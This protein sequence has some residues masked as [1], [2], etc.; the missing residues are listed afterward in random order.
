MHALVFNYISV[1]LRVAG[2][3]FY[4]WNAVEVIKFVQQESLPFFSIVFLYLFFYHISFSMCFVSSATVVPSFNNFSFIGVHYFWLI[5]FSKL[6]TQLL[7][8][9]SG[10]ESI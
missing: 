5:L 4:K 7:S 6:V 1:Y 8:L 9:V 10:V 3:V 2:H